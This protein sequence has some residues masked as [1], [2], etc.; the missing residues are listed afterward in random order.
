MD[1]DD[2]GI[3]YT[4]HDSSTSFSPRPSSTRP[5]ISTNLYM[6]PTVACTFNQPAGLPDMGAGGGFNPGTVK[7][8]F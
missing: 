3:L 7:I 5:S 1:D 4:N 2:R 8:R 6:E